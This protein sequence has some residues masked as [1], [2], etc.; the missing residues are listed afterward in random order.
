[1]IRNIPNRKNPTYTFAVNEIVRVL[2]DRPHLLLRITIKGDFFPHRAV[3][4]LIRIIT[5]KDDSIESLFTEVA[6]DN[7][8][9]SGYLPIIVRSGTIQFGYED[10][11]WGTLPLN[12][13]KTL[14]TRLDRKRLAKDVVIVNEAFLKRQ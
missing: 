3:D 8:A 12:L 11:V 2:N 13:D 7:S 6:P 4:P 10:E 14:I 9:I 5:D 1:M